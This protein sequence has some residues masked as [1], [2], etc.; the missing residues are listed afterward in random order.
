MLGADMVILQKE[1]S[2]SAGSAWRIGDYF[3]TGFDTPVL[4]AQQVCAT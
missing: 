3:A 2:A 4:D 1:E